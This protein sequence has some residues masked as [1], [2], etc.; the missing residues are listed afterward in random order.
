MLENKKVKSFYDLKV[1][2][3][4]R[5]LALIIY[6]ITAKFP[7]EELY[8]IISQL[9]RASLSVTANIAEGFGRFHFK[10]KIK[11]YLQA[12]GSLLE[13][14]NFIFLSQDLNF[15]EKTMARNIF[16][17]CNKIQIQLNALIKA[18]RKNSP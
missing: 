6:K 14:Q 7:K 12:R 13:V 3:D 15:I 9:R 1:W 18:N 10:E 4:S 17:Q 5:K 11:F 8:G 16:D 2:Q